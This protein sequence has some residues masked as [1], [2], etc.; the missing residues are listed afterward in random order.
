MTQTARHFDAL[1]GIRGIAA[2]GVVLYH[3]RLTLTQLLPAGAI[4]VMGKG[5]L[6]V[7]LFFILSG[8]VIWYN[9]A[10]RISAG[11]WGETGRFLW[12]RLARIWPLHAALLACFVCLAMVLRLTGRSLDGYPLAELPLHI[13]LIQNWG[14][15][16]SL[17]WNHPAWSI[18]TEA[19]AYVVMPALVAV[20][21]RVQRGPVPLLAVAS[22]LLLAIYALF[23]VNGYRLLGDNI[24]HLGLWRC[25]LEFA[26]GNVLCLLWQV[27]RQAPGAA[28][29][30]YA[31]TIAICLS[32]LAAGLPETA[33][34]PAMFFC[35]LLALALD[36]SQLA[37][38]LGSRP[39]AYLGEIS[40]STYLAHFFLFIV[41]KM[42][43]VDKSLQMGWAGLAGYLLLV[44]TASIV[45]Y[46][47]IEKPAQGWLNRHQP[48]WLATALRPAE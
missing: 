48:Q 25:L 36:T 30:A 43:F 44:L 33:L 21:S 14:L 11:S 4:A 19:A 24:V 6:A 39:I 47:G 13:L 20:L 35:G 31:I 34:A 27:W 32:G 9:Y 1:T 41:F 16:D 26:L 29:L 17:A 10:S 15:T 45:L 18:S 12:R 40:Y 38:L 42:G 28:P 7:D 37:R 3:C 5:Y 23:A 46:H 8:F 22:G 2:W